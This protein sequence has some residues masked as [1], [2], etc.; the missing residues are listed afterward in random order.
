[1]SN[2]HL[3][4]YPEIK[5]LLESMKHTRCNEIL[6]FLKSND[7]IYASLL[8]KRTAQSIR[9]S[10]NLTNLT[11]EFE[12]YMDLVYEQEILELNAIYKFAFLDAISILEELNM[13]QK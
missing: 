12:K 1:M 9:F 13:L 5:E 7:N 10:E 8:K 3:E 4:K 11:R 6:C 2:H